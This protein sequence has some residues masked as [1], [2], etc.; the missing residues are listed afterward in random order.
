MAYGLAALISLTALTL[1][2]LSPSDEDSQATDAV[3]R[4]SIWKWIEP[5][6]GELGCWFG[7][8]RALIIWFF[9]PVSVAVLLNAT[10]LSLLV[11]K[12]CAIAR[13]TQVIVSAIIIHT[14]LASRFSDGQNFHLHP[15]LHRLVSS[16]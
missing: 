3:A 11:H 13:D 6:F 12:L 5:K 14:Q 8:A 7:S 10:L 15:R 2:L 1:D 9:A 4:A 16:P